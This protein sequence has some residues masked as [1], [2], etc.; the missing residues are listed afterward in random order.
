MRRASGSAPSAA[1]VPAQQRGAARRP[2]HGAR[3]GA[4]SRNR[5]SPGCRWRAVWSAMPLT[6]WC[7]ISSGCPR[8]RGRASGVPALHYVAPRSVLV[9]DH[10]TRG[11]ALVH[12]GPEEERR[13]L[14]R[15]VVRALRGALPQRRAPAVMRRPSPPFRART[16]WPASGAPRSTSPPATSTSWCSP[17]A[18]PAAMNSIPSRP[19]ARCASSTPLLTCTTA[20][21]ATSRWWAPRPRR[22]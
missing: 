13:A 14:R 17:A 6:T 22:W 9:F 2:A 3:A 11:I 21:S 19:I 4:P 18:S 1:A 7:A 8:A 16:I 15:E 10:L 5:T 12:A 20:C